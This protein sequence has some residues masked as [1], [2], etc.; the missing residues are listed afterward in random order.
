MLFFQ[1]GEPPAKIAPAVLHPL[2]AE[3]RVELE[4]QA[5]QVYMQ[6]SRYL[7]A[8]QIVELEMQAEAMDTEPRMSAE[9]V[10]DLEVRAQVEFE[11]A[12]GTYE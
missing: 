7:T 8:E 10:I 11:A 12:G 2:T 6:D 1:N 3:Q 4:T 5:Y 9:Q